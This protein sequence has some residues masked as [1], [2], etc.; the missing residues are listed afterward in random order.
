VS[1]VDTDTASDFV[2]N[3]DPSPGRPYAGAVRPSAGSA[4]TVEVI[5]GAERGAWGPAL[6]AL[7]GASAAACAGIVAWRGYGALRERLRHA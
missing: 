7:A 2:D 5:A 4:P 1:G 6:W 3:A